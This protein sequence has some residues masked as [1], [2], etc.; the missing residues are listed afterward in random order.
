MIEVEVKLPI[1]DKNI[2]EEK[3]V[4]FGFHRTSHIKERDT[5]FDNEESDIRGNGLALRIRETMNL[6]TGESFS[7]INFKGKKM[8]QV[9]MSRPEY[10]T[11]VED[12]DVMKAILESLG[13]ARA[14]PEVIKIRTLLSR[15]NMNACLDEVVGLGTFLELEI[16]A[17]DKCEKEDALQ[18]IEVMLH[19]LG[20]HI[21]DTTTTSYLTMLQRQ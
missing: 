1:E 16:V 10:E 12:A 7:Q 13:Y 11:S 4:S 18:E 3:L 21:S 14:I 5:Y 17:E 2:I 15:R 20:Y 19:R 9:S 8:D 6:I